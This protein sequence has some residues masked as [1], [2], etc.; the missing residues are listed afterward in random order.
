MTKVLCI[1]FRTDQSG[2]HEQQCVLSHAPDGVQIDFISVHGESDGLANPAELLSGYDK[3]VL[4]GLGE[5]DLTEADKPMVQHV[6]KS[7]KPVIEWVIEQDFPTMG[8][9]FGHQLIAHFGG[10]SVEHDLE[11]AETGIAE[12]TLT[13]DGANSPV[14]SDIP[15]PFK[16]VVGHKDSVIELPTGAVLL[17]SNHQTRIQAFRVGNNVYGMQF[18]GELNEQDL[19]ER[20][21]MYP[22]YKEFENDSKLEPTPY[23]PQVLKNFLSL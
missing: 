6:L 18:H 11:Q 23:A 13:A 5:A 7:I 3:L 15:N 20:V 10:G 16:A 12:I 1:Q 8:A 17:A 14:F 2:P 21:R 4:G 9:C 19:I 22:E